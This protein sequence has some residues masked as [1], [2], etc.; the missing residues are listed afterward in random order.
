MNPLGV[1]I[2]VGMLVGLLVVGLMLTGAGVAG[3]IG[4]GIEAGY[5]ARASRRRTVEKLW[6][7]ALFLAGLAFTYVGA[8]TL[9]AIVYR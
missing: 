6:S 2:A 3:L 5:A 8:Y 1:L 7:M 9:Y 4:Q